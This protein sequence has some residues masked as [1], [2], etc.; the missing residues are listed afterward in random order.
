MKK[1]LILISS[2]AML[3]LTSCNDF[4]SLTPREIKVMSTVEDYRDLMASYMSMI[5]R[6]NPSQ[7]MIFGGYYITPKFCLAAPCAIYTGETAMSKS[8]SGYFD[9]KTNLYTAEGIKMQTWLSTSTYDLPWDPSYQFLGPINLIIKE[10]QTA[11]GNDENL[12][13]Y[14]LGE[15]LVWRAFTYFQLLKHYTPYK[16]TELGI[17]MYLDP[18]LDI[19][20][21]M[22]ERKTPKECYDQIIR[23]LEWAE[24]LYRKTIQTS[25]TLAFNPDF[26]NAMLASIYNYKAMSGAAESDDW[27]NA[28]KYADLAIGTREISGNV[29][30]IKGLFDCSLTNIELPVVND[31]LIF[32][33][34]DNSNKQ[35]CNIRDEY[36]SSTKSAGTLTQEYAALFSTNDIRYKAFLNDGNPNKY[37]LSQDDAGG[38]AV[39]HRLAESVLIKAE[40]L[41]RQGRTAEG[42]DVLVMFCE[43]RY[44]GEIRQIPNDQTG[45]ILEILAE[46]KREFFQEGDM[47]WIDM[48]RTQQTREIVISGEKYRL[49]PND[50]RYTFPIPANEMVNNK[51]MIQNPGWGSIIM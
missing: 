20:N 41:V 16:D 4:L 23:D 18:T 49:E 21:A 11:E 6:P 45:L 30:L 19:G 29:E 48:K 2:A 50:F 3:V 42:R 13:Q 31:E 15:A 7:Q 9:P 27:A 28:E 35:L 47:I 12:R 22:P 8:Y 26:I 46:R 33:I 17:P 24:D 34:A 10:I 25:W 44:E 40:A 1:I 32:R 38:C 43:K 14:V 37:N 5:T 39:P 36:Y 51:N